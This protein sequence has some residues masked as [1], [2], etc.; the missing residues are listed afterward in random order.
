M[1]EI[2]EEPK[3]IIETIEETPFVE[4]Q[5]SLHN[6]LGF[7]MNIAMVVIAAAACAAVMYIYLH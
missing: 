1:T 2:A 4:D 5:E 3:S 6:P 7:A